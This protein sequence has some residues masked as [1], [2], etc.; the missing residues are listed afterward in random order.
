MSLKAFF[1]KEKKPFGEIIWISVAANSRAL[2][3]RNPFFYYSS[4][5]NKR[6]RILFQVF[7]VL[8]GNILRM[9]YGGGTYRTYSRHFKF[10]NILMEY[11][12]FWFHSHYTTRKLCTVYY[13]FIYIIMLSCLYHL[14]YHVLFYRFYFKII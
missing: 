1:F 12:T 13:F 9:M 10:W 4:M 14:F 8:D 7:I 3:S 6:A 11:F 2:G 5:R